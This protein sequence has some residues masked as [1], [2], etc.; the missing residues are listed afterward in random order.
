MNLKLKIVVVAVILGLTTLVGGA[1]LCRESLL[2]AWF[3]YH[4][5]QAE[6]E[7]RWE[8]AAELEDRG[9]VAREAVSRWYLDILR[10]WDPGEAILEARDPEA[11]LVDYERRIISPWTSRKRRTISSFHY[12]DEANVARAAGRLVTL[13]DDRAVPLLFALLQRSKPDSPRAPTA[14]SAFTWLRPTRAL[15]FTANALFR[16]GEPTVGGL[17]EA[18]E[19]PE[20]TVRQQAMLALEWFAVSGIAL[21]RTVPSIRDRMADPDEKIRRWVHD[22]FKELEEIQKAIPRRSAQQAL[23]RLDQEE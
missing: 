1:F 10:N 7:T 4:L 19:S 20:T 23:E 22:F 3:R 14:R 17:I 18:L 6:E 16:F 8:L 5:E 21:E 2:M 9:D 13:E 12:P 15:H 11:T